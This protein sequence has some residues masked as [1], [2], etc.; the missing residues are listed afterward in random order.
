MKSHSRD[1]LS[2]LH[3]DDN[4]PASAEGAA[5]WPAEVRHTPAE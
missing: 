1:D 3:A 2:L 4:I 5:N